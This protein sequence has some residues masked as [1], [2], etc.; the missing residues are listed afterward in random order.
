MFHVEV[1]LKP[2]SSENGSPSYANHRLTA[3]CTEKI[4]ITDATGETETLHVPKELS[5]SVDA[6]GV[7]HLAFPDQETLTGD[8]HF[9]VLAPDGAVLRTHT[10][11]AEALTEIV[12]IVVD[13]QSTFDLEPSDN[14]AFGKP[15]KLRGRVIDAR[16]RVQLAQEQVVVWASTV[17][18]PA[19]TDFEPVAV[20]QTDANGYFSAAY[21]LGTFTAAFGVVG[22]EELEPVSI[23]LQADDSFPASVI[24]AVEVDETYEPKEVSII[25]PHLPDPTDLAEAEGVY[26]KDLGVGRCVDFHK[27]N[28]TL[29]EFSYYYIVRT[30][31]PEIKGI[32]LEAPPKIPLAQIAPYME[33]LLGR[34]YKATRTPDEPPTGD[35]PEFDD[36]GQPAFTSNPSV[37]ASMLK[38]LV[39]DPE[40]LTLR[41]VQKAAQLSVHKDLL[42]LLDQY[43]KR[44]PGRDALT[45]DNPVDWDHEPT[46]YQACTIAHGHVLHFK[47]E[48]VADGYSLGDLLYS[49]PLAPCQK[50]QIVVMDWERREMAARREALTEQERLAA[51]YSRDR[52]INEI[53]NAS[54]WESTEGGSW[55]KNRS[56]G[57]GLGLGFIGKAIGGLLG[58]GGGASKS[59]A[60]A[61]QRSSRTTAANSLQQ[62]RDR[63]AQAATAVRSQRSTVIQS[64]RQ[65]ER[66]EVETEVVGNHNHCHAITVQYF[67]VLRHLLVRQRLVD[68]QE[69]LFVPLLMSTFTLEKA[70]RWRETLTWRL[71]DRALRR[72]FDALERIA[73]GYEGSDLPTGAY[74]D[75][76]LEHLEGD[77]YIRFQLARPRD[78]DGEFDLPA[79]LPFSFLGF[80][81]DPEEFY[82]T[83]LKG[84]AFK[85]RI[86]HEQ[87]GP[88]IAARFVEQLHFYAVDV[89]DTET[90]LPIDVTLISP[91]RH[92]R[93]HYISLRLEG[94]LPP[95]KRSEIK[96]IKISHGPSLADIL[97]MDP[98]EMLENMLSKLLPANSRVIVESGNLRYRTKYMQT[99]LFRSSRI[100]N[101]LTGFDAVLIDTPLTR[102]ELRTPR[103]EDKELARQLLAHLNEHIEYY[104]HAIWW[105]M[106]PARRYMLLDG[107]AAP[108]SGGRSVASVVENRLLGIAGNCMIL[109]VAPGNH[110]DPTFN[111]DLDDPIDLLEHYQPT[112]PIEPVRL[113]IPTKGVFAE[114]VMGNCNSC[115]GMEEDRFW[116]WEESP[117]PDQPPAILPVSTES[118]RAAPPDLTAK[119]FPA[120]MINLQTA[121]A[122]PDPTGL[123]AAMKLLGTADLFKD[124]TG[125]TET[126]KSALASLQSAMKMAQTFGTEAGKLAL[127]GRMS[128]DIDKTLK[129]LKKAREGGQISADQEKKLAEDALRAAIGG[130]AAAEKKKLTDKAEVKNLL[131]KAADKQ[132]A[133]V[134]LRSNGETVE[135]KAGETPKSEQAVTYVVQAGDTLTKIA[136][137]F[138]VTVEAIVKA[139]NIADP[140]VIH[141]GQ[142]LVIPVS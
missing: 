27:P 119:D 16:G 33:Y 98:A 3:L 128:K 105:N 38:A 61:W 75:E 13:P 102:R 109:P 48:W 30:T 140:N 88:E 107:F 10:V 28:R 123:G 56:F 40:T 131:T 110:L 4:E 14:P 57:G 21:P 51:T 68:V 118:R 135:V 62:L 114:S 78:K 72:G 2:Q 77:L 87:L 141:P 100:R 35:A 139:N 127:Q 5:A 32:T 81:F 126:Q 117:C 112:T 101:D 39:S 29:D 58:I 54:L 92:N 115:E 15:D 11:D 90:L 97:G 55:A 60:R 106:S 64:V 37:D 22:V 50:K 94:S 1:H 130:G 31:E 6:G 93:R 7:A 26:S 59:S 83:Y 67:E 34:T 53:V 125:L 121:P 23:R 142:V 136:N 84:Q 43:A 80:V 18:T 36:A 120:P 20:A 133:E 66:V 49:L 138:G 25:P 19:D 85:D 113:A 95:L 96:Y 8:V 104:H 65:G 17:E 46:L 74:A 132:K 86:F 24:L 91:Y 52:D 45:C 41:R 70:L 99:D 103:E 63:T 116:R 71:R 69:C 134:K 76:T 12:E 42:R 9:R 47:Q 73:N 108:N 82:E 137:K 124:V 111:Q 89:N 122:A 129:T 79:W 44:A